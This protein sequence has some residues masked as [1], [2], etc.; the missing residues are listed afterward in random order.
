MDG[1]L[2]ALRGWLFDHQESIR[3]VTVP[4]SAGVFCF[5][6][7]GESRPDV[8]NAFPGE[9]AARTSGFLAMVPA[10]QIESRSTLNLRYTLHSGAIVELALP[11]PA[12]R[13]A[14]SNS[15]GVDP[16]LQSTGHAPTALLIATDSTPGNTRVTED[17][18]SALRSAGHTVRIVELRDR[19]SGCEED[20]I[21]AS[22]DGLAAPV[23]LYRKTLQ[24]VAVT[25]SPDRVTCD[26]IVPTAI[27]HAPRPRIVWFGTAAEVSGEWQ[28]DIAPY[29]PLGASAGDP[30]KIQRVLQ[31][32]ENAGAW[33]IDSMAGHG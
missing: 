14:V 2:V 6:R 22:A 12:R 32:L 9:Q 4:D 24:I 31:E 8:S 25:G 29:I 1:G 21:V 30:E 23:G 20:S 28:S 17:V 27:A 33:P 3:S 10:P 26:R 7:Y 11:L 5:V 18:L 19:P 13:F 15:A 16:D